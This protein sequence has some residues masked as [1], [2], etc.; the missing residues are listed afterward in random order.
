MPTRPVDDEQLAVIARHEPEPA[1]EAGRIEDGDFD[2]RRRAAA[3]RNARD[4]PRT[5]IQS[6]SRRTATPRSTARTSA[7]PIAVADFVGAEDVA[8][9]RDARRRARR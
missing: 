7:S 2:A 1:A 5:P 3:L 8:L 4:V 6:S 9:E